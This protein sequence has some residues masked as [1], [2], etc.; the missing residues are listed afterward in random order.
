MKGKQS[1]YD[2]L[3]DSL[4]QEL[5]NTLKQMEEAGLFEQPAGTKPASRLEQLRYY[6][7]VRDNP[8]AW[9]EIIAQ[10]GQKEAIRFARTM[11]KMMEGEHAEP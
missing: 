6:A 8:D 11:E 10:H 2:N 4:A 1:T 9:K 3:A 7:R 5:C